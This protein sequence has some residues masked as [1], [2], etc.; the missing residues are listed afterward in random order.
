[1]D[2]NTFRNDKEIIQYLEGQLEKIDS[3]NECRLYKEEQ[4]Q[5][6]DEMIHFRNCIEW[7][8][9]SNHVIKNVKYALTRCLKYAEAMTW[10][11]E[12]TDN[13]EL[14]SYYLEDAVYRNL[15]LWDIF[16]QLLNEFYECGFS[17]SDNISIYK[18]LRENKN[19]IG[20]DKVNG[21]LNY[22]NSSDHKM[23]RETLRNSFTH[24]VEA[25]SSYFFHRNING[26]I[27]PQME[28]F[29]PKHPFENLNF[30]VMDV[31]K[32]IDLL[33]QVINEMHEYRN[34]N[35]ILLKVITIMPCGKEIED[36]EYWN[37]GILKE[38]YEQII[39]PCETHCDK[40]NKYNETYV[41]K[42]TKIIFQRIHS[43]PE[44]TI[45]TLIPTMTFSEIESAF[46]IG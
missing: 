24:S 31:L 6:T 22:I 12:E 45:E 17:E 37:F 36:S 28:Y 1:M 14:Y 2:L 29:F 41:C 19:K 27:Q 15:V 43:K 46:G 7:I 5:L 16:R 38:K 23:V 33:N 40:A 26:K 30:V 44:Q 9:R 11:L 39:V 42:P 35:F 13:K 34:N 8:I 3:L 21:I 20:V 10:P 32:L 25:T 18:F 4:L